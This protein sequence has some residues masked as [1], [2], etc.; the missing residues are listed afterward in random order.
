MPTEDGIP[1][2]FREIPNN[3]AKWWWRDPCLRWN[4]VH[5]IGLCGTLFFAGYDGSLFNG[6]QGI[7]QWQEYFGH[8]TGNILGLAGAILYLP[9]VVMAFVADWVATRYGRLIAIWIGTV[10]VIA[11]AIVNSAST[12]WGMYTAG[13]AVMG[14]GSAFCLTCGLL[15]IAHPRYRATVGG[16]FVSWTCYATLSYTGNRA[17]RLPCY[18]QLLGPGLVLLMTATA[19]ESPRWLVSV[20]KNEKAR[21]LLAKHHANGDLADPLINY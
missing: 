2:H 18:L 19:P 12:S 20:G 21:E 15:E 11:G 6:L 16:F 13:R 17:W 14:V 3:T 1:V 9:M 4:M 8:P 5:C 10:I 7:P